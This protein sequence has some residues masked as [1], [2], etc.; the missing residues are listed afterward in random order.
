MNDYWSIKRSA[1]AVVCI[2]YDYHGT[3]TVWDTIKEAENDMEERVQDFFLGEIEKRN[4]YS[5][6]VNDGYEI[7]NK[8]TEQVVRCY[9]IFGEQELE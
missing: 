6:K 4:F 5:K 7:R 9:K 1:Y 3:V 2:T 8:N